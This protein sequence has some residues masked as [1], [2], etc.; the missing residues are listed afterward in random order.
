MNN[1]NE[2]I[3]NC[4]RTTA[5]IYRTCSSLSGGI[6][7]SGALA[8][9]KRMLSYIEG[10]SILQEYLRTCIRLIS[11]QEE[12]AHFLLELEYEFILLLNKTN[13]DDEIR[14]L[15]LARTLMDGLDL[16]GRSNLQNPQ[17]LTMQMYYELDQRQQQ[18]IFRILA[19][20]D[21]AIGYL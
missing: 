19:P 14:A 18:E 11:K 9:E 5:N 6:T 1:S 10:D 17:F 4:L 3:F 20:Q 13:K 12:R 2:L 15:I 7:F 21:S 16:Q 8:D